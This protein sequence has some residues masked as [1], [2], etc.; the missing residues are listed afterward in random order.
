MLTVGGP[1]GE[2]KWAEAGHHCEEAFTLQL[3][4]TLAETNC[5]HCFSPDPSLCHGSTLS[6]IKPLK[7]ALEVR[8]A[9]P[10]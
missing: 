4:G 9:T 10:F 3:M 5:P 6:A 1:C 8:D 7:A 2:F